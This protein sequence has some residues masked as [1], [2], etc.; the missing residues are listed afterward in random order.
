MNN[1]YHPAGDGLVEC[2]NRSL[3]ATD[4]FMRMYKMTGNNIFLGVLQ[5]VY[6][7]AVHAS[8]GVSLFEF[9]FGRCAY[10][11]SLISK[12]AHDATSYQ[13]QLQAKLSQLMDSAEVHN[14]QASS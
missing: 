8:T 13:H 11:H 6:R 1:S 7:T 3:L 4:A 14:T 12:V 5:Y 10:K 9:M 2:F